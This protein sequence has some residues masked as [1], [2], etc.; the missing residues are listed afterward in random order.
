MF[1]DDGT[2][3]LVRVDRACYE[4]IVEEY[5]GWTREDL[6]EKLAIE[7]MK[8]KA[9]LALERASELRR[10]NRIRDERLEYE[11]KERRWRS[12]TE[13]PIMLSEMFNFSKGDE[14]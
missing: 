8:F 6:L 5:R 1:V 11:K 3:D 13:R 10:Q 7:R 14:S 4:E 2:S 12:K 9:E